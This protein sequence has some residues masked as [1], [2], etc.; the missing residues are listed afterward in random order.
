MKEE[1]IPFWLAG[2]LKE[3]DLDKISESVTGAERGTSAEIVP[4]IVHHSISIGHVP[5]ILFLGA[6]FAAWTFAVEA[7]PYFPEIPWWAL[8]I[9]AVVLAAFSSWALKHS[10]FWQRI[11]TSPHDQSVAVA[12]RAQLEFYQSK[13]KESHRHTGVLLFVSMLERRA[14]I[15]A[16]E[17]V[18]QVVEDKTWEKIVGELVGKVRADDFAGGITH[19]IRAIGEVL[20]MKLPIHIGDRNE[21]SNQ[22]IIKT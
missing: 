4:M 1:K 15:L 11:M 20:S 16:D 8:Q 10:S 18:A 14:V 19:A 22:L 9:S 2:H 6:L 13:I 7:V 3:S 17:A 21:L 5:V 12:R